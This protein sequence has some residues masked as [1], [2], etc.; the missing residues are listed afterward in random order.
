MNQRNKMDGLKLLREY[1]VP[2]SVAAV[3]FDPQYRS[4]LG[5]LKYGNEGARMSDRVALPQ[6]SNDIIKLFIGA[7]S[8]ALRPSGHC[9]MWVDKL[10]LCEGTFNMGFHFG[11]LEM[12]D[13]ITWAK[14]RIGM[15]YRTRRKCEYLL[16]LQKIPKRAKG[17]WTDHGIPDVWQEK[18]INPTHPHQKPEGLT[19]RLILAITKLGDLVVDPCAGSYSTM[20]AAN[21]ADRDFLGCDLKG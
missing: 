1:V 7:I 16:V 18:I 15:G 9:F 11:G 5:K 10:I 8:T 12:V 14:P 2:H 19:Q 3:I 13:L 17:I 20:Y 21:H 4:V 6:M